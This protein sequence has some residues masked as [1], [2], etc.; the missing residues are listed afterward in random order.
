M[1]VALEF[2]AHFRYVL[3]EAE[4]RFRRHAMWLNLRGPS[5][6]E[7]QRFRRC[8]RFLQAIRQSENPAGYSCVFSTRIPIGGKQSA[9][10]FQLG[11]IS[12]TLRS[13]FR[14]DIGRSAV[15]GGSARIGFTRPF[16]NLLGTLRPASS[17]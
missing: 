12:R 10:S 4:C 5:K 2:C 8:C 6:A 11:R 3:D 9:L 1:Q 14:A 15:V 16:R 17:A 13:G 7:I